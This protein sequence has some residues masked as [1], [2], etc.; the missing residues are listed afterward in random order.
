MREFYR[1]TIEVD[2]FQEIPEALAEVSDH[3]KSHIE[4]GLIPHALES[5]YMTRTTW[6]I[7]H[8]ET[9]QDK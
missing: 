7:E 2:T 9:W 6:F 8:C 4:Q 1:V 3:V 5:A